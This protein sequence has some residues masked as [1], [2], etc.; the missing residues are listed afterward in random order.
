MTFGILTT[1]KINHVLETKQVPEERFFK[2]SI[3]NE[4]NYADRENPY[5][6]NIPL[7]AILPCHVL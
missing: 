3:D 6:C 1:G 7:C 2:R 4:C 5:G